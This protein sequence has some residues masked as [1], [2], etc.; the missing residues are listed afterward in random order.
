MQIFPGDEVGAR[1]TLQKWL[2]LRKPLDYEG[3]RRLA[4]R[5]KPYAGL[6]YFHMLLY[7][8]D[9]NGTLDKVGE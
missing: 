8:L 5:W 9:E 3:A 2:G 1:N 4:G 7:R 6:V